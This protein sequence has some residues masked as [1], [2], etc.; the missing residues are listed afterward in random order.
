MIPPAYVERCVTPQT[1]AADRGRL[2]LLVLEGGHAFLMRARAALECGNLA[3]FVTD[4]SRTQT[5]IVELAPTLEDDGQGDL[6]AALERLHDLLIGNLA[7]GNAE[8][9][10]EMI[11][12]MLRGYEPIVDAYRQVVQSASAS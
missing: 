11:D 12:E 7:L 3:G 8:R 5:V 1:A 10:R 2:L 4:V 9:S 6:A